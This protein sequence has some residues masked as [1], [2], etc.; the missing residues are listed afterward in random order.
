MYE[1]PGVFWVRVHTFTFRN[2]QVLQPCFDLRCHTVRAGG[3]GSGIGGGG[4]ADA[5]KGDEAYG[6]ETRP[7]CAIEA[8][9]AGGGIDMV[10][11]Q[12]LWVFGET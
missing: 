10:L 12:R 8:P 1:R 9:F 11:L 3:V 5:A 2:L 6:G 4:A 7:I